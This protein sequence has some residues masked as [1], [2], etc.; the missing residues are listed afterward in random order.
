MNKM[1]KKAI[2]V[3]SI[4][5]LKIEVCQSLQP[6][7]SIYEVRGLDAVGLARWKCPKE[8]KLLI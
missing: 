7:F 5:A 4:F 1:W 2:I 8:Q 6:T 3:I